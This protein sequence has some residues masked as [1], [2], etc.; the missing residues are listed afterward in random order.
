MS[1]PT[2]LLLLTEAEKAAAFEELIARDVEFE[3]RADLRPAAV[4][5]ASTSGV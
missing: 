3:R 1:R 4:G 2:V 5:D